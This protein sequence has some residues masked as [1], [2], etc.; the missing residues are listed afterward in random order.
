MHDIL[1]SKIDEKPQTQHHYTLAHIVVSYARVEMLCQLKD[2]G[3]KLN[4]CDKR[5]V[6][7]IDI[8]QHNKNTAMITF[9]NEAGITLEAPSEVAG[10]EG[11]SPHGFFRGGEKSAVTTHQ[12]DNV[13]NPVPR[14]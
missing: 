9:F 14:L 2:W 4:C 6:R 5:G 13:L 10:N 11:H 12:S 7:P 8:A 1:G 3:L